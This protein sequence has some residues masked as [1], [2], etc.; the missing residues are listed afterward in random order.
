MGKLN[1]KLVASGLSTP[2][3]KKAPSRSGSRIQFRG[4]FQR[5]ELAGGHID[6]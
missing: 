6:V 3:S 4:P 5:F 2:C 1:A